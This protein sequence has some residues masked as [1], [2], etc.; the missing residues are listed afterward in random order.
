MRRKKRR[1]ASSLAG[2]DL[3]AIDGEMEE[4]TLLIPKS[5]AASLEQEAQRL[6]LTPGQLIRSMIRDFFLCRTVLHRN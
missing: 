5:Q 6:G 3:R 1:L 4:L 2:N